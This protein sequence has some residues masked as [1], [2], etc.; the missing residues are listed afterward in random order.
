MWIKINHPRIFRCCPD[1]KQPTITNT[2]QSL[3]I[4]SYNCKN[5]KTSSPAIVELFRHNDIVLIQEHWL[6]HFQINLLE[7]I[8]EDINAAGKG[9]DMNNPIH[10]M[11]I[12]RGYGGVAILWKKNT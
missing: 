12:P 1:P 8:H 7:Q 3:K 10:P 6:F 4:V 5:V 11:Q 2:H 9:A